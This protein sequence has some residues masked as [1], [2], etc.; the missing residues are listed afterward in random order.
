MK[1]EIYSNMKNGNIDVLVATKAFGIGV[2]IP[3]SGM[4][5]T[6]GFHKIYRVWFK[7]QGELDGMAIR[8][9]AM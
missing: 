5:Y 3:T 1:I 4:L 7:N 8:H 9:T 2:N 6:W